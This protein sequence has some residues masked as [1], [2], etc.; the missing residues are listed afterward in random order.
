MSLEFGVFFNQKNQILWNG[1]VFNSF[2]FWI[3]LVACFAQQGALSFLGSKI[4]KWRLCEENKSESRSSL[5][6]VL[7][8]GETKQ[9]IKISLWWLHWLVL[10]K[11]W[12]QV[13]LSMV[14][15][16]QQQ[17]HLNLLCLKRWSCWK[18]SQVSSY[19]FLKII[20]ANFH[21]TRNTFCVELL[22]LLNIQKCLIFCVLVLSKIWIN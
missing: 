15:Q 19:F 21:F 16:R 1:F 8:V 13:V 4:E 2:G 5:G 14:E 12:K 22:L 9:N 17:K 20:I 7:S 18:I 3:Y 10:R 11:R 6:L